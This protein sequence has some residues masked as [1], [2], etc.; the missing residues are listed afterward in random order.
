L[1]S[2]VMSFSSNSDRYYDLLTMVYFL[3]DE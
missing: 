3:F 1:V 2:M